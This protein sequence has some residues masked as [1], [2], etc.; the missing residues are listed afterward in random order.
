MPRR[1][2]RASPT[3][4]TEAEAVSRE[5]EAALAGVLAREAAMRA[6]RRVAEAALEAAQAQAA[7]VMAEGERLSQQ[8]AS[9]GEGNE[10]RVAIDDARQ[11]AETAARQLAEAEAALAEP[12]SSAPT[13]P[14]R[15][16]SRKAGWPRRARR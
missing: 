1:S 5:A 8:L 10:Q 4:L 12:S 2:L 6:E 14:R 15:A 11:A 13:P 16:T 9:I 7:R 3:E